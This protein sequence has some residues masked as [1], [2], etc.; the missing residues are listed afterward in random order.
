MERDCVGGEKRDGV[1]VVFGGGRSKSDIP[2]GMAGLKR[3]KRGVDVAGV[4]DGAE[5]HWKGRRIIG[6]FRGRG[7]D[8]KKVVPRLAWRV[9]W[10]R[11]MP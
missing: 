10:S 9:N 11:P 2:F 7:W 3:S 4:G 6:A 5:L 8:V 1:P